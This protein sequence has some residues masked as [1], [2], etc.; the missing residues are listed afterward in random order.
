VGKEGGGVVGED[1]LD[2]VVE[3]GEMNKGVEGAELA[4]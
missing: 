1:E 4:R 3:G 2:E